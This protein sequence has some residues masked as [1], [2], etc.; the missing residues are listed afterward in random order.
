MKYYLYPEFRED[1]IYLIKPRWNYL[2]GGFISDFILV[3]L[4]VG[5]MQQMCQRSFETTD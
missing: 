2:K 3:L 1:R 5:A 4:I